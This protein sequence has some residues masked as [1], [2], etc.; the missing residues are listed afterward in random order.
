MLTRR[1]ILSSGLA[2]VAAP[3]IIRASSKAAQGAQATP[4]TQRLVVLGDSYSDVGYT[5]FPNWTEQL[6]ARGRV[7]STRNLALAGASALTYDTS[8]SRAHFKSQLDI[9]LDN[10]DYG[11]DDVTIVY[12]GYNDIARYTDTR[13]TSLA[14]CE[15]DYKAG[16]DRLLR[17]GAA[18]GNRRLVPVIVHDWSRNPKHY[19]EYQPRTR[20]WVAYVNYV[21]NKRRELYPGIISANL[22]KRFNDVYARPQ[23][24]GLNNVTTADP[25]RSD[26][27]A[28]YWNSGHFGQKGHA[29]MADEFSRTLDLVVKSR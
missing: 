1:F 25:T 7:A 18:S 3:S 11:P 10:P 26:T 21:A 13:W 8:V 17:A 5:A 15:R 12:F 19:A 29:L 16:L 28:L 20:E 27:T 6:V 23:A 22:Y 9:F 14:P 4:A 24:Y 2:A